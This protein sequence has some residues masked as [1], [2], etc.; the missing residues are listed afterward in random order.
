MLPVVALPLP[1][2]ALMRSSQTPVGCMEIALPPN[3]AAFARHC[4]L[5]YTVAPTYGLSTRVS[6]EPPALRVTAILAGVYPLEAAVKVELA[7]VVPVAA[8]NVTLTP[9]CQLLLFSVTDAGVKLIAVLP[10]RV[11]VTTTLPEGTALRRILEVALAP[12]ASVSELGAACIAGVGGGPLPLQVMPF[13]VKLVGE[14]L[15]P[16]DVP[17]KPTVKVAP[18]PI[19]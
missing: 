7:V 3:A 2:I 10:A 4:G 18:L 6:V 19:V 5:L 16:V 12:L 1:V 17:L 13:S 14:L 9:L 11:I 8:V 15:V